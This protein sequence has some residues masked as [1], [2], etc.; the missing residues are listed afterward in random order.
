MAA[1]STS[2]GEVVDLGTAA[3][4]DDAT[5][6]VFFADGHVSDA[7]MSWPAAEQMRSTLTSEAALRRLCEQHRVPKE[8]TPRCAGSSGPCMAPAAGASSNSNTICVYVG[9]LEA[10]LRFPLHELYVQLLRHYNLA[11]SQLTPNAWLYMAAFLEVCKKAGAM[12]LPSVFRLFFSLCAHKGDGLGWLHF[13]PR[14]VTTCGNSSSSGRL[15][16]GT[17]AH[18]CGTRWKTNFFFLEPPPGTPLPYPC[19]WGKPRKASVQRMAMKTM[20]TAAKQAALKL[21]SYVENLGPGSTGIDINGVVPVPEY[22]LP[23]APSP[24]NP[25]P[26]HGAAVKLEASDVAAGESDATRKRKS[27]AAPVTPPPPSHQPYRQSL[28]DMSTPAGFTRDQ[29]SCGGSG[30]FSKPTGISATMVGLDDDKIKLLQEELRVAHAKEANYDVRIAQLEGQLQQAKEGHTQLF[31]F[32][33]TTGEENAKLKAEVSR[34]REDH[35]A[36]VAKLKQ[37]HAATVDLLTKHLED[38]HAATVAQLRQEHTAEVVCVKE[39]AERMVQDAKRDMVLAL[40]PH[41]DA[42]LLVATPKAPSLH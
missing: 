26:L 6:R 38:E 11:P 3:D 42:S 35:T 41:L 28:A 9:A 24:A 23:L 25:P 5:S 31:D 19:R 1:P 8:Y 2:S 36:R 10:G 30:S 17:L 21:L 37:E 27:P 32:L 40:F 16:T 4:L 7:D 20:T 15:V 39:A 34:L 13:R 22:L 12:P 29:R 18:S 14:V 33:R